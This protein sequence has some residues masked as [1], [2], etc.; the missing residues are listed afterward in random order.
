MIFRR[1]IDDIIY[2]TKNDAD[3][4]ILKDNL[5]EGFSRFGLELTFREMKTSRP[6]DEVE[7]L[8]VL[9]KSNDSYQNNF[10]HAL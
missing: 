5:T 6:N 9:H 2:I 8:D 7:F 10:I 1:F 3:A 4:V